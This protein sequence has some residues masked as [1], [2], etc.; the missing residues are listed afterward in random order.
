MLAIKPRVFISFAREDV[1]FAEVIHAG[2]IQGNYNTFFDSRSMRVGDVF[3]EKI[4]TALKR[5]DGGILIGS[6]F[7]VKSVWCK[8]EA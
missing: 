7:S 6:P 5:S 8:V 3:P 2:L 1:A 4:V